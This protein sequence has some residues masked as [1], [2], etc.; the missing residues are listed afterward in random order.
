M[1]KIEKLIKEN[2][3]LNEMP[4]NH[5]KST[6]GKY[7]D[8]DRN[9]NETK[10]TVKNSE[11]IGDFYGYKIYEMDLNF[12]SKALFLISGSYTKL[13]YYFRETDDGLIQTRQMYQLKNERGLMRKF[14][15]EYILKKYPNVISDSSLSEE[16][17]N[18]WIKIITTLKNNIEF[19]IYNDGKYFEM[20][21]INSLREFHKKE[22]EMN[23]YMFY[24]KHLN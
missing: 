6:Y 3:L 18:F 14:F 4:Y 20:D 9:Y 12:G 15:I 1:N 23:D 10:L 8:L 22:F 7:E 13:F 19:G 2:V 21:D 5:G 11:Y 16:A 17:M 24:I